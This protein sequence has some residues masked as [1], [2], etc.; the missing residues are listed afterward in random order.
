[1]LDMID[2]DV[3]FSLN[4]LHYVYLYLMVEPDLLM[5]SFGYVE[6]FDE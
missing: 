6:I 1:M 4:E 2:F 5:M 3:V